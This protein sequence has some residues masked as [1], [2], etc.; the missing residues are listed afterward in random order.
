MLGS[1]LFNRMNMKMSRYELFQLAMSY[2]FLCFGEPYIAYTITNQDVDDL[3]IFNV[4][5]FFQ[6]FTV[7]VL[8]SIFRSNKIFKEPLQLA[9]HSLNRK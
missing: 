2:M 7:I 9:V 5:F 8:L 6:P 1:S 4:C 3:T